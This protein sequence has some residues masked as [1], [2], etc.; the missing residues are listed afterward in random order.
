MSLDGLDLNGLAALVGAIG[1]AVAGI[2][3]SVSGLIGKRNSTRKGELRTCEQEKDDLEHEVLLLELWAFQLCKSMAEH[4]LVP[5]PRPVIEP[6]P[7]GSE[8]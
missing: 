1:T 5:I 2:I 3:V 4:G 7:T 8:S 6:K